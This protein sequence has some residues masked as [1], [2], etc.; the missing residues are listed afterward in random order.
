MSNMFKRCASITVLELS[1][2]DTSKI[3]T[4][5]GMFSECSQLKKLNLANWD[6]SNATSFGRDGWS[7]GGMFQ[8]CS[9]LTDLNISNWMCKFTNN[10]FREYKLAKCKIYDFIIPRMFK[11]YFC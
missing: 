11:P 9:Q 4:F 1:N 6:V 2:F 7:Y 10:K 3:T 5:L 8:N